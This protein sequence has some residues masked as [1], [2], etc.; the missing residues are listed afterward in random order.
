M[1][2]NELCYG[3]M[4]DYCIEILICLPMLSK[5]AVVLNAFKLTDAV[6]AI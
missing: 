1:S 5:T 3:H 2:T 4:V 6:S